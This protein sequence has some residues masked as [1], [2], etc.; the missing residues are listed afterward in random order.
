MLQRLCDK[1]P[2]SRVKCQ[3]QAFKGKRASHNQVTI[4]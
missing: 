2:E 3:L 4:F 1:A